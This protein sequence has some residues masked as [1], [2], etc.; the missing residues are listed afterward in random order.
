MLKTSE[1]SFQSQ[2]PVDDELDAMLQG[3][4]EA[5]KEIGRV[6]DVDTPNLDSSDPSEPNI[7]VRKLT[8]PY[9][10]YVR[11]PS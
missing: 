11:T 1:I 5:S 7:L 9:F 6:L 10:R 4:V 8:D 2:N 3:H